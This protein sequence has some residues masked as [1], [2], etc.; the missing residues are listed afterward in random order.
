M[1]DPS[2]LPF[3]FSEE[4]IQRYSRTMILPK[5]GGRGQKKICES[6]ALVIGAGGLGSPCA[7]YLAAAG[8][9]TIGI[10]DGDVVD[11]SNLQRQI[12]HSTHDVGRPK[13]ESARERLRELNPDVQVEA[14]STRIA[15]ANALSLIE[16]Y[17]VIVD[18]SDNFSTRFL[19]ND[20]CVMA[21]KPLV[22]AGV[23]QFE[24]QIM[25]I[26]PGQGPCYRCV[27]REPPPPGAVPSCQEAGILG[28]VAG[29]LG[30]LQAAEA[31]K[32]I[33]GV[34]NLLVGRILVMD[35]LAMRTRIVKVPKADDC[36]V[37]GA[38]PSIVE[39][40][41]VEEGCEVNKP[42]SSSITSI[43]PACKA[44]IHKSNRIRE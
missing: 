9:G 1:S 25:T 22:H 38:E 32:V 42:Q 29:V 30:S 15:A 43:H 28:A 37:C 21:G 11:L 24:G 44:K 26:L 12:L 23:F 14:H 41:D 8:V 10:A 6:K 40:M 2:S 5:V 7:Y 4:Q 3:G 27:F 34:G 16:S 20:A 17:D 35:L 18:G 36:P 19:V 31:L 33:L 13:T 39:L